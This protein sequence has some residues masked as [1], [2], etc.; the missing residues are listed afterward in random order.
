[1]P[2]TKEQIISM[3]YN[4]LEPVVEAQQVEL[5]DLELLTEYGRKVLRLYIEKE[6]GITLDDCEKITYAIQPV[7][8]DHD[9]IP[10]SYIL[11]VSSPGI[12]RKLVKDRHYDLHIG[13]QV[14]IKLK[15]PVE[16]YG[17]RKKFQGILTGLK[18]G[19][20]LISDNGQDMRLPREHLAYCRLIYTESPLPADGPAPVEGPEES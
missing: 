7:L 5:Y 15:K 17:N 19:T 1:M 9:P 11:E 4:M 12:E 16:D 8:D 6:G 2:D 14:E 3:V 18:D 10:D 20:I 13:R